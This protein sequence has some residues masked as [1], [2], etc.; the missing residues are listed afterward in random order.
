MEEF[1]EE[2]FSIRSVTRLYIEGEQE[3]SVTNS[4][5][6]LWEPQLLPWLLRWASPYNGLE[7]ENMFRVT[8]MKNVQYCGM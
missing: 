8:V 5:I 7:Q 3:K 4:T 1:L 2:V 6:A